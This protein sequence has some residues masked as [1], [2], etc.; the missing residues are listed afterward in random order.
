MGTMEKKP[1]N[2]VVYKTRFYI[3]EDFIYNSSNDDFKKYVLG[4][5][6]I[7]KYKKCFNYSRPKYPEA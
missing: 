7:S 1:K 6:D 2:K 5:N 4:S 3:K